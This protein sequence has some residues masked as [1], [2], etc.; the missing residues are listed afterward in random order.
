MLFVVLTLDYVT[1]EGGWS[2]SIRSLRGHYQRITGSKINYIKA[3]KALEDLDNALRS[4]QYLKEVHGVRIW[5]HP[6]TGRTS[7]GYHTD[8]D[9]VGTTRTPSRYHTDPKQVPAD[10]PLPPHTPP[11]PSV[12][13]RK[14]DT[15]LEH[16]VQKK[17]ILT[18]E[19]WVR[20][21]EG[22][23]HE[24]KRLEEMKERDARKRREATAPSVRKLP[25]S[26]NG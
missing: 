11:S 2:G 24:A 10:P 6:G 4:F 8:L 3:T 20:T 13:E 12:E 1:S 17:K 25:R 19:E 18:H 15:E 7:N 14:R 16:Q 5:Y 26:T 23:E 22:R 9:P 21:P